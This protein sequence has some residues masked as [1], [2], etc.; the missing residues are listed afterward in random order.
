MSVN[1]ISDSLIIYI[2][3][4]FNG[5]LEGLFILDNFTKI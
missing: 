1:S 5:Y 3:K 2:L 4:I